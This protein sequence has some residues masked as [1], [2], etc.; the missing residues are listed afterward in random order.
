MTWHYNAEGTNYWDVMA[1]FPGRI[2]TFQKGIAIQQ[3]FSPVTGLYD[4]G[5]L[6]LT[7]QEAKSGRVMM[8]DVAGG[9]GTS[10]EH[11]L[12][13]HPD[14]N[15]KDFVLQDLPEILELAR[16]EGHLPREVSMMPVD[17]W[18]G[19]PVKGKYTAS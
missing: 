17:F 1:R 6:K 11:I 12:K 9:R 4:Y 2:E 18:K 14:L 5:K 19:Q 3:D 8:V 15:A 13:A 7:P 16:K 10:I